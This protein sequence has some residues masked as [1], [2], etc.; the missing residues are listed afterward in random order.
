MPATGEIQ[1]GAATDNAAALS[2][3]TIN[4]KDLGP[5]SRVKR[6]KTGHGMDAGVAHLYVP[7]AVLDDVA[8][9]IAGVSS[10]PIASC[11]HNDLAVVRAQLNPAAGTADPLL[12]LMNGVITGFDPTFG[13]NVD[14]A[15]VTIEDYRHLLAGIQVIGSFVLDYNNQINYTMNKAH[16]NANN[17]PNCRYADMGSQ[18]VP[19][20][21]EPWYGIKNTDVYITNDS[22]GRAVKSTIPDPST[23]PLNEATWWTP[24]AMFTYLWYAA[25]QG[26]SVAGPKFPW[27]AKGCTIPGVVIWPAGLESAFDVDAGSLTNSNAVIGERKAP[28]RVYHCHSLLAMM[29]DICKMEGRFAINLTHNEDG[30]SNL[31]VVPTKYDADDKFQTPSASFNKGTP[32]T[33]GIGYGQISSA[34]MRET[35]KSFH[36]MAA[37]V[38]DHPRIEARFIST[39]DNSTTSLNWSWSQADMDL[40]KAQILSALNGASPPS[41][42]DA[43]A[44]VFEQYPRL[45]CEWTVNPTQDFQQGTTQQGFPLAGIGRAPLP[46]LLTSFLQSGSDVFALINSR[47]PIPVEYSDIADDSNWKAFPQ[48]DGLE[49]LGNGGLSFWHLR[50]SLINSAILSGSQNHLFDIVVDPATTSPNIAF[51]KFAPKRIR[52][53]VAVPCDHRLT[54]AVKL[55]A[56]P[57]A[58]VAVVAIPGDD[59]DRINPQFSRFYAADTGALHAYE[60]RGGNLKSYPIAACLKQIGGQYNS[61]TYP[62]ADGSAGNSTDFYGAATVLR[63]DSAGC[64]DHARRRIE[65]TGRLDRGGTFVT[66]HVVLTDWPGMFVDT[67]INADG[68]RFPVKSCLKSI[69]IDFD[70]QRTERVYE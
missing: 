32:L 29:E 39:L 16:F 70:Q 33:R 27:Y 44:S 11:K 23:Q 52:L 14:E 20:F 24:R 41:L 50:Q 45:F 7:L 17:A 19:F 42:S 64:L 65:Q 61:V 36:S 22:N 38:G 25:S 43:V 46:H 5:H 55:A 49:I 3:A 15:L 37:A 40:A 2:T 26:A 58:N 60:E 6:F 66:P 8:P 12:T 18:K 1:S 4:G 59:S 68:T 54:Q 57:S 31:Q 9:S 28:E 63:D 34:A 30:T 62:A 56:D 69:D 48:P 21:C 10:S 53:T 13:R 47:R 67:L 35:S 51:S